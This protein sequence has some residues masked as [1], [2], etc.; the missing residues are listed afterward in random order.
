MELIPALES[1]EF[2]KFAIYEDIIEKLRSG[3]ESGGRR[4]L[5]R[6]RSGGAIAF[7]L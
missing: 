7:P 5:L 4:R 2:V 3:G 6:R 1:S